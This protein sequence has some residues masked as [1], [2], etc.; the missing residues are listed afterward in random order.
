MRFWGFGNLRK[1]S[2]LKLV[3][4]AKV[5]FDVFQHPEA[6]SCFSEVY[7]SPFV[8]KIFIKK[9]TQKYFC[10]TLRLVRNLTQTDYLTEFASAKNLTRKICTTGF[11]GLDIFRSIE[12]QITRRR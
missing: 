12:E 9:N 4:L 7:L 1:N 10:K 2:V 11:C 6:K 3:L 5:H 8:P